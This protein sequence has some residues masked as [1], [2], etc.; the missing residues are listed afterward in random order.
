M[1]T[2]RSSTTLTLGTMAWCDTPSSAL[3]QKCPDLPRRMTGRS[4]C[5]CAKPRRPVMAATMAG[6]SAIWFSVRCRAS[7]RGYVMKLFALAIVELLR[8]RKGLVGGPAPALAT[9]LLQRRQIEQARRGLPAMLHRHSEW[10]GMPGGG[11]GDG[12][13]HRAVPDAGLGRRGMAHEEGAILD[14]GRSHDLEIMLDAEISDL[15]LAQADDG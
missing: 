3:S 11:P 10:A 13:G 8:D 15:D 9:G 12:F 5:R 6:T 14:F 7:A 4:I 1:R 2:S